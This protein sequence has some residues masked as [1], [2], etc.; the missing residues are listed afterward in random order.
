MK[1]NILIVSLVLTSFWSCSDFDELNIN[2]NEPTAVSTGVLFTSAL[3]KSVQTTSNEAFLLSNNAAQLTAK[4]LR[5]E[6]DFYNWNSFPTV[7]EGLYESLAD[8]KSVVSIGTLEGNI[9]SV[10]A[11]KVLQTWVFSQLTN[12]YGNIPYSEA[13][14]GDESI[15]TPKY[16]N[17][18]SIY[19]AM[20]IQLDAAINDLNGSG[21]ITGDILFNGQASLWIKFANGLKLRLL[22]YAS[23]KRDVST[24][25][26]RIVANGNLF[27]SNEEQAVL[28]FL[29][30]FPNQFPTR[31]LKQGDFDAVAIS[32][33]AVD[34]MQKTNDPRLSRYARPDNEDFENPIFTGVEN[35]VGG[36]TG[37]RLGLSYFDYPGQITASEMNLKT[38]EGILMTYAEIEFLIA[39]GIL[40]GWIAGDLEEHYK[41]GI[42][43][44]HDYYQVAYSP[45]GWINFDDFYENSGVSYGTPL[46]IW[47]QKWLSL[48]FSGLDPY[49][50]VRRWY[51]AAGGWDGIPFL[52]P[53][54]GANFNNYELPLRFLYPGQEQSLNELNYNDANSSYNATKL[55]NGKMWVVSD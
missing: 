52:N 22:M 6:V 18:E 25:F 20:L 49:F 28:A 43:A 19:S 12:A 46:D 11:A 15:F 48:Y 24:E 45:F 41:K 40:N 5:A 39:E 4:T 35:G 53:P 23:K 8:L 36:Q 9:Q 51:V 10:G 2:P 1:L 47:E 13:I 37:S 55:I 50:E 26:A 21:N 44:S 34:A 32:K 17:Q 14:A 54:I 42:R 29:N 38:A 3:R 30:G 31:P 7:W 33:S 16:D 27:S